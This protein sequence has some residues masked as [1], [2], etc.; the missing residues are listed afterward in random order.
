MIQ[1]NRYFQESALN[2]KKKHAKK[3]TADSQQMKNTKRTFTHRN[4]KNEK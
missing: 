4:F 3:N 1:K 2:Q